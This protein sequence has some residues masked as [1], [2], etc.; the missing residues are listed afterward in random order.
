MKKHKSRGLALLLAFAM[1]LQFCVFS[2][3]SAWAGQVNV[4]TAAEEQT[5]EGQEGSGEAP[6][7]DDIQEAAPVDEAADEVT[8]DSEEPGVS[9]VEEPEA[10][11]EETPA[12]QTEDVEEPAAEQEQP[13]ENTEEEPAENTDMP[14]RTLTGYADGV[15]V[16]VTAEEGTFDKDVQMVV[17][18]VS[19]ADTE[20]AKKA[21]DEV[22]NEKIGTF[23]AVDI[24]FVDKD[25]NEVQPA[26]PVKVDLRTSAIKADAE[27]EVVHIKD[28]GRLHT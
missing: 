18:K 7:L 8:T 2:S 20:K 22:I 12:E 11:E 25:G 15:N 6:A 27:R 5:Q 13:A 3:Q 21:A 19:K 16:F 17:K 9:D 23:K 24:T 4:N 1:V 26:K 28:N 10:V 14:A